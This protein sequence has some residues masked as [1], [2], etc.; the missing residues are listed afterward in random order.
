MDDSEGY[1]Q[2]I[3]LFLDG[4]GIMAI[5]VYFIY[6]LIILLL[7]LHIIKSIGLSKLSDNTKDKILSWLPI[8][9][10]G[11]LTKKHL[12]NIQLE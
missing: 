1:Y 4:L 9:N 10:N 8:L 2:L 5:A 6:L 12:T 11:V 3:N 7:I